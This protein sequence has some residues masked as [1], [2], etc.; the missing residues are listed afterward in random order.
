MKQQRKLD[1]ESPPDQQAQEALSH[2]ELAA[3]A[4]VDLPD[5][6]AMSTFGHSF[7]HAFD[8]GAD[9]FAMPI[10]EATATNIEST[11]S[12][13]AADADQTVIIYQSSDK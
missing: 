11:S 10:N 12:V 3:E 6:E 5:R 1:Q 9:N 13:A 4:A 8:P 2:D 7:G